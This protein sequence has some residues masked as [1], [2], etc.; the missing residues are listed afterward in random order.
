MISPSL[1]LVQVA[2]RTNAVIRL[3]DEGI[4]SS[5]AEKDLGVLVDEKLDM[6]QQCVLA[7]QKASCIL[8]CIKRSVASRSRELW[9]P[10]PRKDMDLLERVQRR[11]TKMI[12][13]LEHLSYGER[14]QELGLFSPEN[15]RLRGDLIAAF[16]YLKGA[17]KKDGDKLFSRA[18]CNSTRGNGFK[19]KEGRFRLDIRKKVFMMRVAKHWN[20]LPRDV[21][22][23]PSLETFKARLDGALSNLI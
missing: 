17:Y 3:G 21:V 18:C 9:S 11:A 15:R 7:A 6:S 13:G 1:H 14:L 20:R 22:D 5:P 8:D 4:E 19:L 10:Q 16:Q 12:R 23:A 2:E